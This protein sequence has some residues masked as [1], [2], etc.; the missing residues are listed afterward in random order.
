MV[1]GASEVKSKVLKFILK[2]SILLYGKST[3]QFPEKPLIKG[4][5]KYD[6]YKF[7]ARCSRC[8][9]CVKMSILKNRGD[10]MENIRIQKDLFYNL[11]EYFFC[12]D[13]DKEEIIKNEII[14]KLSSMAARKCYARYKTAKSEKERESARN[15]YMEI[16]G[17]DINFC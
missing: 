5:D 6:K 15:E 12:E 11:V 13:C 17:K 7:G 9:Q 4:F 14:C 1:L 3:Y 16:T 10:K 2:M 8:S